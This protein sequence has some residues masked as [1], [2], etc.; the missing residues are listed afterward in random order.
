MKD[1]SD[2][3]IPLWAVSLPLI[4]LFILLDLPI[5]WISTT[6]GAIVLT[7]LS[8]IL[9]ILGAILGGYLIG[10]TS[11]MPFMVG[12]GVCLGGFLMIRMPSESILV[13]EFEK[14]NNRVNCQLIQTSLLHIITNER[15][16]DLLGARIQY[17]RTDPE[18]GPEHSPVLVTARGEIFLHEYPDN[19]A[20]EITEYIDNKID[21]KFISTCTDELDKILGAFVMLIGFANLYIPQHGKIINIAEKILKV[22][23]KK[24]P[25]V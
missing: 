6:I 19:L 20:I 23:P 14:P 3:L 25:K 13:C 5:R 22:I 4:V 12:I 15:E 2:Y 11:I 17:I 21:N 8:I 10:T 24:T 16:F 18:Y 9:M 7:V 1:I